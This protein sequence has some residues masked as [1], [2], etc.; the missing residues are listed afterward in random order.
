MKVLVIGASSALATE[1][2]NQ[3]EGEKNTSLLCTQRKNV[4][5]TYC[6]LERP[7]EFIKC[8]ADRVFD[9]ALVFSGM[10]NIAQCEENRR[11]AM[12]INCDGVLQ[13]MRCLTVNKWVVLSTNLVFSGQNPNT[14]P[15]EQHQP[16]NYYGFTKSELE[17]KAKHVVKN[18]AIVRLSKVL[19]K[20]LDFWQQLL[21]DL[22]NNK[23]V[24]VFEDM[25]FA[26]VD[27]C[28]VT[29]FL[30]TLCQ[31]FSSGIYQLSASSDC[32]YYEA[33]VYLA[34]RY[35]LNANLIEPVAKAIK[36]PNYTSMLVDK[37]ENDKGFFAR[38]PFD[39]LQTVSMR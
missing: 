11:Q 12:Q 29:N 39:V 26:P 16:F 17:R 15:N 36:S 33:A 18:L 5:P 35:N 6:D 20:H 24:K 37:I 8:L 10:T 19:G 27:L 3:I 28:S 21:A 2:V 34:K 13:L 38:S 4:G 14:V 1:F 9:V 31:Q 30:I 7:E 23:T 25:N 22:K 32:S